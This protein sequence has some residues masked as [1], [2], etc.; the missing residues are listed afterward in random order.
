LGKILKM[1][2]KVRL[3][4]A[5]GR[6]FYINPSRRGPAVPAGLPEIPTPRSVE[7]L[8]AAPGLEGELIVL[9]TVWVR[10]IAIAFIGYRPPVMF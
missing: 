2:L 5:P 8:Q 6:G 9:S 3:S 7:S 10:V 1:G 4:G